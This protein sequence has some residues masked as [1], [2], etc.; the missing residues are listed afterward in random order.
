MNTH[1]KS[2]DSA[3]ETRA[4]LLVGAIGLEPTTPTMSRYFSYFAFHWQNLYFL[5]QI[6]HLVNL[7]CFR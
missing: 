2:P 4:I 5:N 7:C 1:K 3:L 6:N